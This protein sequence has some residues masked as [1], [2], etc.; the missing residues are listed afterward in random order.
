MKR[1]TRWWMVLLWAGLAAAQ[2]PLPYIV[3]VAKGT[4]E[5]PRNSE[6][7]VVELKDGSWL[8]VWCEWLA[9]GDTGGDFSPCNL[10]A[11][12]SRD[13]GRTWVEKRTLIKGEPGGLN[14]MPASILRLDNGEIMLQYHRLH[15][16][17]Q[18]S[19]FVQFS[20]DEGSTW[21][22]PVRIWGPVE[23]YNIFAANSVAIQMSSG[24]VLVPVTLASGRTRGWASTFW[25]DDRGRT[26][27]RS[28]ARVELPMRGAMEATVAERPDRTLLMVMRTQLGSIFAAESADG[29]RWSMS[30]TLGIAAPEARP[31]IARIPHSN[32]MLLV[33]ND[34][35]Y[36]PRHH[37]FGVRTPIRVAISR[38]GGRTWIN[39]KTIESDP[40]YEYTNFGIG[41]SSKGK[42]ILQYMAS[43]EE[44][45][46]RFGRSA[47]G[48]RN[49]II[50]LEWLRKP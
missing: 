5:H 28:D 47:I 16:Q 31:L 2:P 11:A 29:I 38:D 32:E 22:A 15:S 27:K 37:H 30:R 44:P 20:R 17:D 19:A 45:G 18:R 43:K 48:L 24:R 35:Q 23:E 25:S 14:V 12:T 26:W 3:E 41:F 7:G 13:D 1:P 46:G 33:W 34:S 21:S 8:Q 42:A 4:A 50:P 39:R 36:D 9:S 49:A 40:Q 6:G 10:V